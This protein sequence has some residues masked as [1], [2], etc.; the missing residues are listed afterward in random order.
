MVGFSGCSSGQSPSTSSAVLH[1]V[2][3]S[4]ARRASRQ[5]SRG[6]VISWSRWETRD[7]SV[8]SMV[9]REG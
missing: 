3:S 1:P 6:A 9:V 7:S 8:S 4:P 2:R 5:R